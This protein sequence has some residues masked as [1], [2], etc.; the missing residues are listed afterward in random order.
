MSVGPRGTG[1]GVGAAVGVGEG[2]DVGDAV[3]GL[4]AVGVSEGAEVGDAVV[5][6]EGAGS[7]TQT[8]PNVTRQ[9]ILLIKERRPSKKKA[10]VL[11][12]F[13]R[14]TR[15]HKMIELFILL[16]QICR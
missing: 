15:E 6:S 16:M 3:G 8:R 13:S 4:V 7:S 14:M 12:T 10:S 2:A 1:I 9:M 11:V 5:V